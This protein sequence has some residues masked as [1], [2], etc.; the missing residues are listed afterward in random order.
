MIYE[1]T[2]CR[3][4]NGSVRTVLSLTPTP[5]ANS[6]PDKPDVEAT[7][8]RLDLSQCIECDHVQT[9]D[10]V[11]DDVLYGSAYKYRTP[12]QLKDSFLKIAQAHR[13][14][15]PDAK[16]VLE[17]G[18][19]N[20]LFMYALNEAGFPT[21]V[22]IDPACA[23]PFVWKMPFDDSAAEVFLRRCGK[24][25]LI[26]ANNVFAHVDDLNAMFAAVDKVLSDDGA[27]I[28]EVQ[29]LGDMVS[30]GAFDMI[31]HEHRDYHT[32]GP[33]PKF[34]KK[35]GLVITW[36]ETIPAHGGSLRVTCKRPGIGLE[37]WDYKI[38][39][40]RFAKKIELE[41]SLVRSAL[42]EVSG[43]IVAF[44]AAAKA[45]TLIHHFGIADQISY[46]VDDTVEKQGRYIPGTSIQ[47][48]PASRMEQ[49]PPA[50][51]FLTAWNYESII[52]KRF[53]QYPIIAPFKP[54][55]KAAA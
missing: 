26:F 1:R 24:A 34:L 35:H 16:V 17:I 49:E 12:P 52:R 28:F 47:I 27:L 29:S 50:V 41:K 3:L 43:R 18:A 44:G 15:Y 13:Q 21:C 39:W 53:P 8:Y 32:L 25:D 42:E 14:N 9:R 40:R 37:V 54:L 20:G 30:S 10:V 36:T 31:Y 19:N 33:L 38:D 6:F 48:S 2:T 22:G 46:C 55:L 45:T 51:L 7:R 23:D 11:S 5:I 4:C